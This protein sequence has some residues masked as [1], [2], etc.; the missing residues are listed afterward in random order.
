MIL[1]RTIFLNEE[2][3]KRKV[4]SYLEIGYGNGENFDQII[5]EEKQAVDPFPPYET[6]LKGKIHKLTSDAFFAKFKDTY[7][8]IFIDGS[9]TYPQSKKDLDTA[10]KRLNKGGIVVMHD[11]CPKNEEYATEAWCG[12]VYRVISDLANSSRKLDWWTINDDH[13]VT[14]I[15]RKVKN[16]VP[17]GL[18]VESFGQWDEHKEEIMRFKEYE[19]IDPDLHSV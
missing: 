3:K 7:D 8:M 14:F 9:H 15:K 2:I 6:P 1:T 10:L 16:N 18:T 19:T 4:K 5:A 17:N 11:T 12:E 13:G